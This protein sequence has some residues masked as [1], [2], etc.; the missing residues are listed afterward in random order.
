MKLE[1]KLYIAAFFGKVGIALFLA[2]SS[3]ILFLGF[4]S[5]QGD[6]Q[7]LWLSFLVSLVPVIISLILVVVSTSKE[8]AVQSYVGQGLARGVM[9]VEDV[10]KLRRE[11]IQEEHGPWLFAVIL[12]FGNMPFAILCII[13]LLNLWSPLILIIY[14]LLMIGGCFGYVSWIRREHPDLIMPSTTENVPSP[15]RRKKKSRDHVE[16]VF[17]LYD[18][19]RYPKLADLL[20]LLSGEEAWWLVH[21][22]RHFPGVRIDAQKV[23]L[24]RMQLEPLVNDLWDTYAIFFDQ[25]ESGQPLEW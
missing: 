9:R 14:L 15:I 21:W 12:L 22:F 8:N 16:K 1:A 23:L 5:Q 6:K 24:D 7:V 2:I 3:F 18:E 13:A 17:L 11:A 10:N 19:I 25:L 4:F 20:G